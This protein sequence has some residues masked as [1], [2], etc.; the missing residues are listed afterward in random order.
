MRS[1]K[2]QF[3]REVRRSR[4]IRARLMHP[5]SADRY[6]AVSDISSNGAKLIVEGDGTIPARFELAFSD[7]GTRCL[8]ELIWWHG[9]SAGI[10]FVR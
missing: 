9:K 1:Q 3:K 2:P 8:C 7:G 4:N 10:K 5:G 6:C